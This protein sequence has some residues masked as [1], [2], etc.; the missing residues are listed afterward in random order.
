MPEKELL[1]SLVIIMFDDIKFF[2]DAYP[3][4][5]ECSLQT[6]DDKWLDKSLAKIFK[7][8]DENIKKALDLNRK[9]AGVFFSINS[10][11][12]WK[13]DKDNVVGLNAYFTEIDFWSKEDQEK[14]INNAPIYPSLI[15]ESKNGFHIYYYAKEHKSDD[16][17][18]K[19]MWG[20]CNYYGWDSKVIDTSRVLR[21][22][23][24]YHNKTEP[25]LISVFWWNTKSH[26]EEDMLKAFADHKTTTQK[27]K[28]YWLFDES[29]QKQLWWNYWDR[30]K[31]LNT[32][33]VLDRLSWHKFVSGEVFTFDRNN[34]WTHQI[35]I[36]WKRTGNW[37]DKAWKPAVWLWSTWGGNWVSYVYWYGKCDWPSLAKRINEN[38]PEVAKQEEDNGLNK[39]PEYIDKMVHWDSEMPESDKSKLMSRWTL[40][41]DQK[42]WFMEND[43]CMI[44]S[45]TGQGKTL[46]STNLARKNWIAG[47]KV[48]F[49]TIELTPT[50]LKKRYAMQCM[51]LT[52]YQSQIKE[53]TQ[54]E[55]DYLNTKYKEFDQYFDL[56]WM[57]DP[58][59]EDIEY[60]IK[61][62]HKKWY[63]LIILD[64]LGKI[65]TSKSMKEIEEQKIISSKLQALKNSLGLTIILI[66]HNKKQAPWKEEAWLSMIRWSQKIA[67]DTTLVVAI[68]RD[69]ETN[70]TSLK[71]CKV[72]DWIVNEYDAQVEFKKW[73][74]ND[75]ELLDLND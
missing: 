8:T 34:N 73:E 3:N 44:V 50:M 64:N 10:M 2:L 6:F 26:T 46:F 59:I 11:K 36:N 37:I 58:T 48:M 9:G 67:D 57:K 14:L 29:M 47:K 25:Y 1:V 41:V 21:I 62:L 74:F 43:Y 40:G 55:K 35:I 31:Q 56:V 15:V 61:D 17:R 65:R 4:W 38:Y 66:H 70:L 7:P 5:R 45:W 33:Q 32:M 54:K 12:T 69:F 60:L 72:T 23:W 16:N 63:E 49:V 24:A 75:Y 19:I 71:L 18:K 52:K 22:P 39:K 13:R 27:E 28:D 20:L 42:F 53:Y 68:N 51:W 30:V